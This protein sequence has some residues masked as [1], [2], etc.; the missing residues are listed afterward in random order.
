MRMLVVLTPFY[1][2]HTLDGFVRGGSF[3]L[4]RERS[5]R[6]AGQVLERVRAS[7]GTPGSLADA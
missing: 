7:L 5:V 4:D 6:L 2:T 3:G 1:A